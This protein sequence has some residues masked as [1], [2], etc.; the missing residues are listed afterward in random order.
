MATASVALVI[1][2]PV[3][4]PPRIALKFRLL[5]DGEVSA[6]PKTLL[7]Y[8]DW[9]STTKLEMAFHANDGEWTRTQDFDLATILAQGEWLLCGVD[10]QPPRRTA[11]RYMVFEGSGDYTFDIAEYFEL[12]NLEGPGY[13]AGTFP[14]GVTAVDGVPTTA[15]VRVHYRPAEG[16]LG[17]GVLVAQ[18]QSAPDGT[19]RV[20]GLDPTLK[21]DVIARKEGYNDMILA[22]ISPLP[23]TP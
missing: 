3:V 17:D 10:E 9:G 2:L 21:F 15:T 8:R 4:T 19:W 22:N 11:V 13:L 7:V 5:R 18:V 20:E 12:H 14:G 6:G 1:A 23:N 16:E